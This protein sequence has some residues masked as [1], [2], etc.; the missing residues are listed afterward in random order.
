MSNVT[1]KVIPT[2]PVFNGVLAR[3]V[4]VAA[5]TAEEAIGEFGVNLV[6]QR[7]GEVLKNPTG[8]YQSQIETDR[9]GPS[10]VVTDGGVKYGPWLEGTSSRNQSSRFKGYA[11][12]HRTAREVQAAAQKVAEPVVAAAVKVA[13]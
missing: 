4:D 12:F 13:K 9:A 7:L 11:T 1:L 3:A 6:Q 2:G 8:F 5:Q 10:T